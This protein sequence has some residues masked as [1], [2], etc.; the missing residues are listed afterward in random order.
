MKTSLH[1]LRSGM[2]QVQ[3][4]LSAEGVKADST[5]RVG[6]VSDV[7]E[8]FALRQKP[9]MIFVGA[10]GYGP[11][12]RQ[13]LGSTTEHLLRTVSC[14]TF[15]V[16]PRALVRNHKAP[17]VTKIVVAMTYESTDPA[18][19]SFVA[20]L[21]DE[22]GAQ[23]EIVQVADGAQRRLA[24]QSCD[25]LRQAWHGKVTP[26]WWVVSGSPSEALAAHAAAHG[27]SLIVFGLHR[28]G[29]QMIECFDGIVS[30]TVR[31]ANCP[32]LTVP[33]RVPT[34]E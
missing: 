32:I 7:I 24:Q 4:D 8:D 13:R 23:V 3:K 12:D 27:C 5:H 30:E 15:V 9:D 10:Y 29:N 17:A 16:G 28:S 11:I 18:I 2:E 14:S 21:T 34:R 26:T 22:L 31:Q 1:D 19:F 20:P 6:N 33:P 25:Q